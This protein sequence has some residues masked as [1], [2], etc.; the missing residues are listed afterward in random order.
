LLSR[1][2]RRLT[3]VADSPQP[4]RNRNARD[5]AVKWP[6]D[7]LLESVTPSQ[8]GMGGSDDG[9]MCP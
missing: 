7:G 2:P 6:I 8:K 9:S 5:T 1:G 4:E 3:A